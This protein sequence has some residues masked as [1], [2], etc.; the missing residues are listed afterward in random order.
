M[1]RIII[2]GAT[3]NLGSRLSVFLKKSGYEVVAVGHRQ[4]DNGFF[5]EY[6]IPYFSVDISNP[7]EFNKLPKDNIYAVLH[8]AG[9]L[10]AAMEGFDAN[11]YISSIIQGTLNVLEYTRKVGADRIIFP[12]TLFDIHHL[13]GSSTPILPDAPRE[14]PFDT[15][16]S[17]YVIAKNA[18]CDLIEHYHANFGIKRFIFRLSRVYMYSPNPYTYTNGKKVLISDRYLIY[19]AILGKD[20]EIWGDADRVLET[21]CIYDFQQIILCALKASHDGGFYNIGSG[22]STLRERINGIV[23]IFS[24]EENK[25]K[26]TYCP[27][28]PNSTQFLLDIEKT[29]KELGYEPRYTWKDYLRKFK[30]EMDSQP[31]GKLHGLETDYFDITE[32]NN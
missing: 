29:K 32:F 23:E 28:K 4:S 24:P 1:E 11:P 30:E 14:V 13:F 7:E 5:A 8:F 10:P 22:G 21:I 3:G 15:D 18:A 6:G 16:H 12:Q 2:F 19:R 26:I 17:I 27:E 31:F 25:S 9:M 20:I